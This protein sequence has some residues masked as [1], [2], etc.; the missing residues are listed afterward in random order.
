MSE[1]GMSLTAPW[2]HPLLGPLHSRVVM[3][4]MTRSAA[5]P[6]GVPTEEMAVY[7]ARRARNAIGLILT[8]STAVAA[9]GDGFPDAPRIITDAQVNGWRAVTEAVHSAGAPIFCQLFHAGRITHQ[10]Y[11][12]GLQPVSATDRR[13]DG[14]NRR[15]GKPYAVPR[16]LEA[17][18]L[19][20]VVE[21]FRVASLAAVRAGFDGVE[22]HLA[23]GYLPDQFLDGRVNDRRDA[24]GGTVANRCRF[25]VEL[26]AAVVAELGPARVM[27]RISPSRWMD[28][29]YDWPD[30]PEMLGHLLPSLDDAGLRMLDISCA[31]ADY[32]VTAG[33]VVRLARP[34]WPHTI[35]AGASLPRVTAQDELDSGLVDMV[36]YGRLLIANPDLVTRWR[37]QRDLVPYDPGML[38]SLD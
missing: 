20:G 37:D 11:T 4:A 26:T 29:I 18:E 23:H 32:Q 17:A 35:M 36:T 27:A 25:A 15:N 21:A 28:G 10:D 14:I 3:S 6:D 9:V 1:D 8:E 2:T 34:H 19:P 24:Y 5:G 38:E 12:G 30:L 22:L 7:Y 31:R 16:R 13:A 33:R